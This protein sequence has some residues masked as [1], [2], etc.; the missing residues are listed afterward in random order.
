MFMI[1]MIKINLIIVIYRFIVI[2]VKTIIFF[3]GQL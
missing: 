1:Y 3:E 2:I